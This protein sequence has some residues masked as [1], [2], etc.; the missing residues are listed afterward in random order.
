MR[1]T[2]ISSG[3]PRDKVQPTQR[4]NKFNNGAYFR[5]AFLKASN[6]PEK[7]LAQRRVKL[8]RIKS[9]FTKGNR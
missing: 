5:G 9:I 3:S 2:K 4:N 1:K 6:M 7:T 8:S